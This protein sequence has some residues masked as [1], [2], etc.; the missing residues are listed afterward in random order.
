MKIETYQ[1]QSENF[2]NPKVISMVT[3]MFE[4]LESTNKRAMT[5]DLDNDGMRYKAMENFSMM[6]KDFCK[7][8]NYIT[9]MNTKELNF[10]LSKFKFENENYI[11]E[12]SSFSSIWATANYCLGFN[13][14]DLQTQLFS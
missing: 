5:F 12:C 6:Y 14:S 7:T 10:F 9:P 11:H 13:F 3:V 1:K 2:K 4:I 8:I